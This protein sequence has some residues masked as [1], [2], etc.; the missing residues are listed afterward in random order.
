VSSFGQGARIG[1]PNGEL[2]EQTLSLPYV[3]YS[4]IFDFARHGWL[5]PEYGN[6]LTTISDSTS[7][8]ILQPGLNFVSEPFINPA[9]PDKF[10]Q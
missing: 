3:F 9:D 1:G 5:P 4:E 6:A 8:V 10:K 2:S 7:F